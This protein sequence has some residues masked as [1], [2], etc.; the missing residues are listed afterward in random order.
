M[1]YTV[2]VLLL[3]AVVAGLLGCATGRNFAEG[4]VSSIVIGKTTKQE[5]LDNFKQAYTK[6]L[7]NGDEKWTYEYGKLMLGGHYLKTLEVVF[8]REGRVKSY[9]YSNNFPE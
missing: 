7:D 2:R 8:D 5:I 3:P 1:R 4:P 9:S 6:G